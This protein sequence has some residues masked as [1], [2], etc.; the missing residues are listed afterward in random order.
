MNQSLLAVGIVVLLVSS[1]NAT[2]A[3]AILFRTV[4]RLVHNRDFARLSK[5]DPV[6]AFVILMQAP[7]KE[8]GFIRYTLTGLFFFVM[9]LMAL[10]KALPPSR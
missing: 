8:R 5:R 7:G 9:S 2:R 6:A 3:G 1:Y 4:H 10:T